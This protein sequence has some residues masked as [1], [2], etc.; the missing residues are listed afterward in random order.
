MANKKGTFTIGIVIPEDMRLEVIKPKQI[1]VEV[2][3]IFQ[4][5]YD[6]ACDNG[7]IDDANEIIDKYPI[8]K[9]FCVEVLPEEM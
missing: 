9:R 8:G 1:W 4:E 7:L 5:L 3:K 2:N 6:L